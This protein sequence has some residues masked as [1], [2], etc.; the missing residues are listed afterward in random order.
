MMK[1]KVGKIP[2]RTSVTEL[3]EGSTIA[4]ALREAGLSA[5]GYELRLSGQVTEDFNKVVNNGDI[6]LL[7][8]KIK[9]NYCGNG[10]EDCNCDGDEDSDSCSDEDYDDDYDCEDEDEEF[11]NDNGVLIFTVNDEEYTT[12]R[13]KS[14][15]AFLKEVGGITHIKDEGEDE[16]VSTIDHQSVFIVKVYDQYGALVNTVGS[17]N[18]DSLMIKELYHYS[19]TPTSSSRVVESVSASNITINSNEAPT[20]HEDDTCVTVDNSKC[21]VIVAK[22]SV[23]IIFK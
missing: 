2:G 18:S 7:A 1:V 8:Q 4:D 5:V 12:T 10:C 19:V 6:I 14:F 16:V 9:G 13:P 11:R 21:K 3:N 23:Q 17:H 15:R 20:I 22:D